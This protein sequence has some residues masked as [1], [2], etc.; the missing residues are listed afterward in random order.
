[1]VPHQSRAVLESKANFCGVCDKAIE[2]RALS[3][4]VPH[5]DQLA[6]FPSEGSRA[7]KPVVKRDPYRGGRY[8]SGMVEPVQ[9]AFI[10]CYRPNPRSRSVVYLHC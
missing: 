6:T 3:I 9:D 7:S 4:N 5:E 1:M 2:I 10:R 8:C